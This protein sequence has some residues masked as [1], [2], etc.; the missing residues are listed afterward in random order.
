MIAAWMLYCIAI[1]FALTVVGVALE[2]GL[3]LAG[4]PTRWAWIIA[5]TGSFA[6]PA[7]AWLRP[8]GFSTLA[9]PVPTVPVAEATSIVAPVP[10]E[11]PQTLVSLRDL[12]AALRWGWAVSSMLL[13]GVLGTTA[14]RLAAL[15]RRWRASFVDGRTVLV[16]ENVGPAVA[17][18]WRPEVIVPR[19]ALVFS[20]T[21]RRLMLSHEEEHMRAADPWL[22]AFG[23]A[24]LVLMPWNPALWWQV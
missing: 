21:Q 15:R 23:A 1:G 13:L 14:L 18:L 24:A 2:R 22:L 20:E 7:A 3:H 6:I 9:V 16:S 17:G 11:A 12:D 4:R 10:A 5:L 8:D 19:W